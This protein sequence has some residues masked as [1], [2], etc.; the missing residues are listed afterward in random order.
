MD[1]K[2]E[3]CYNPAMIRGNE[4]ASMAVRKI[5]QL[6]VKIPA[7]LLRDIK[8]RAVE[9]DT[10]VAEVVQSALSRAVSGKAATE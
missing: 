2:I 1:T 9:E 3:L 7:E 8:V 10:T 5:R 4:E 6:N